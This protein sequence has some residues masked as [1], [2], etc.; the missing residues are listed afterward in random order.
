MVGPTCASCRCV[1]TID[2]GPRCIFNYHA[3]LLYAANVL[4]THSIFARRRVQQQP[5]FICRAIKRNESHP[6]KERERKGVGGGRG[7][8]CLLSV[9]SLSDAWQWDNQFEFAADLCD[10]F[11]QTN[12]LFNR[13]AQSRLLKMGA[14]GGC[15]KSRWL[16]GIIL[17]SA[18]QCR[19]REYFVEINTRHTIWCER[20][21]SPPAS[22]CS[23]SLAGY[24][25]CC[26][27][28]AVQ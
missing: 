28:F 18:I 16:F 7:T 19:L 26:C 22:C 8:G 10:V 6:A 27:F 21:T 25:C 12:L 23:T 4:L 5:A 14:T 2:I 17:F 20:V 24:C 11:A 15:R 13:E 9:R 3:I 1:V